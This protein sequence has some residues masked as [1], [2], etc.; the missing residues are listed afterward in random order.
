[1]RFADRNASNPQRYTFKAILKSDGR[2][3]FQYLNVPNL[4]TSRRIIGLQNAARILTSTIALPATISD[5]TGRAHQLTP[6]VGWLTAISPVSSSAAGST[7]AAGASVVLNA[8]INTTGIATGQTRT[9][10]ITFTSND[11]VTPSRSIPF[12]FTVGPP[13]TGLATLRITHGIAANGTQDLLTP[14]GD[15]VQNLLKYA[16]NMLGS[17]AGQAASLATP[18]A[19]LFSANG[20]AG[21]PFVGVATSGTDAGKLQ[22]TYIRRLASASPAPGITYAVEFSDALATWAVNPLATETT[23]TSID[24]TFERVTVTDDALTC[25]ALR[26]RPRHR[27][28]ASHSALKKSPPPRQSPPH[29]KTLPAS[30]GPRRHRFISLCPDR[31][32]AVLAA[33][34]YGI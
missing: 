23:V 8:T 24:P 26:P 17:S 34:V 15:G 9:A 31:H 22:I 20:S 3:T 12:N 1:V 28:L 14:A 11:P 6:S 29:E 16:F 18:N 10:N 32:G 5:L 21:L 19:S 4:A 2:I 30:V 13:S 33:R 7:L 25:Q 27:N